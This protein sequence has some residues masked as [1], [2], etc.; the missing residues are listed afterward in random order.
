MIE[1]LRQIDSL[2]PFGIKVFVQQHRKP[3][4]L[5]PSKPLLYLGYETYSKSMRFFDPTSRKM[6]ISRYFSITQ[7]TFA[8]RSKKVLKKDPITLPTSEISTL[9]YYPSDSIIIGSLFISTTTALNRPSTCTTAPNPPSPPAIVEPFENQTNSTTQTSQQEK[10]KKSYS[11]V[12]HYSTAPRNIKSRI[13]TTNRNQQKD[14]NTA[15]LIDNYKPEGEIIMLNETIP[16]S[17]ALSNKEDLKH[18]KDEMEEEFKS[19]TTKNTGTLVP[20]PKDEKSIGGMWCL[21]KKKNEFGE[22]TRN[23]LLKILLSTFINRDM[24]IFQFDVQTAFLYGVIDAPVY[25]S[26][27][28]NFE[29]SGKE[30]W[31]W[32]LN[33][34]LYG[35]K[36][37]PC[38]W[39]S[40]LSSTLNNIGRYSCNSDKSLFFNKE[41]TIYIHM[42]V[43]NGLVV[44]DSREIMETI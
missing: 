28:S 39:H 1:P 33:K 18:W 16:I 24:H 21:V 17:E 20:P 3:K 7:L 32:K 2:I 8:Y 43:D 41:K 13:S 38:Q 29:I 4:P 5:P 30:S 26:Q 9:Q 42:H 23:K 34:S 25:V 15:H 27:V 44:G 36:Q 31:V 10:T 35:T 12:P 14:K 22:I 19:L 40:H 6:V 11:Y 37:A